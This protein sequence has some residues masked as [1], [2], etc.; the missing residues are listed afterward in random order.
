MCNHFSNQQEWWSA[1]N[2]QS[3]FTLGAENHAAD[4]S[5]KRKPF[6]SAGAID[7]M[8]SAICEARI[9]QKCPRRKRNIRPFGFTPI[10]TWVWFLV[11]FDKQKHCFSPAKLSGRPQLLHLA[12]K[13]PASPPSPPRSGDSAARHTMGLSLPG[14]HWKM[15]LSETRLPLN[16][17]VTHHFPC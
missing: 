16:P 1:F 7:V 5:K 13:G 12:G 14:P 4:S 8:G 15:G 10:S 3:C 2:F 17:L 9:R 6:I 11:N